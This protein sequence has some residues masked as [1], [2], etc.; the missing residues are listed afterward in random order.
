MANIIDG[1]AIGKRIDI[2]ID[3][4]KNSWSVCILCEGEEIYQAILPPDVERLMSLVRRLEPREVHT[5][6]EAGPTGFQLH[7]ALVQAGFDSMVTPPSLVPHLGGRVK[8]DRRDSRKL[9]AMLANGFLRRVHVLS[10]EER[11]DR[12]LLRSRNQ[13]D[14]DRR[15]VMS[16]IKSLLL[17]HGYQPPE[18]LP[19]RWGRA[20]ITWLENLTLPFETLNCALHAQLARYRHLGDQVKTLTKHLLH[21]ARSPRYADRVGALTRIPGIGDLTAVSILI[22]LQDIDR[23]RRADQLASYLGLTPSQHSSGERMHHGHIT[24]CGNAAVRTCLV[25]SS[26]TLIRYDQNARATFERIKQQTGSSKKA[27]TAVA[28]RLALRIRR[29]LLDLNSAGSSIQPEQG[30]PASLPQNVR[31]YVLRSA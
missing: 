6:Y 21:L 7:D 5:A 1:C 24:R 27:I 13:I 31:R 3:A 18:T 22:E 26:W 8:T 29:T 12:Q 16:Q 30:A 11:A 2:G 9:A 17:F 28:R 4:H 25:E 20:Y 23:F 19:E 15:G 14:L 10:Q